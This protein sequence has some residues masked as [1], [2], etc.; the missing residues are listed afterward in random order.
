MVEQ[1]NFINFFSFAQKANDCNTFSEAAE[2][3]FTA[4]KDIVGADSGYIALL[5]ADKNENEVVFLDSGNRPC[6]VDPG[7]PMP[8]RG[9]REKCCRLR[10]AVYDNDYESSKW[11]ELLPSGHVK[12]DN[13]L[14]APIIYKEELLGIIGLANK[15]G[16]FIDE[17][18]ELSSI[19]AKN[20]SITFC[21]MRD[22]E[23]HLESEIKYKNLFNN[24]PV[25]LYVT[26]SMERIVEMNRKMLELL[27]IKNPEELK[28][29]D[30]LKYY[31]NP[32]DRIE[33]QN[34]LERTGAVN[35]L[36][37]QFKG[38]KGEM[39]WISENANLIEGLD[40]QQYC[41][42][43]IEDITTRKKS[44]E[45]FLTTYLKLDKAHLELNLKAEWM[46]KLNSFF[47]DI[48]GIA[49]ENELHKCFLLKLKDYF[50]PDYV[51]FCTIGSD[52]SNFK[53]KILKE[54]N[55]ITHNLALKSSDFHILNSDTHRIIILQESDPRLN[56]EESDFTIYINNLIDKGKNEIILLPIINNDKLTGN[57]IMAVE[58]G[59]LNDNH[60]YFLKG[61]SEF[62]SLLNTNI[63]LLNQAQ[64]SFA[65]LV[66][67]QEAIKKQERI[68]AMG[69]IASGITH[70]IN[71]TLAPITLYTEALIE[72]ETGLSDRAQKYLRNIQNAVADIENVTQRLRTFYKQNKEENMEL[73]NIDELFDDVI[74]LTRPKWK[75]IPNKK[76]VSIILKKSLED[77][78]VEINGVRSDIRE[79]LMNCIFNSVDAMPDGGEI[80]L[81][82]EL[83]RG[84]IQISITDNGLGM[85]KEQLN[86]CMEPF[87][88]TKGAAGTGL[89]LA[90][91]YG[92]VQ[93]HNGEMQVSSTA[94]EGT[95]VNLFFNTSETAADSE[96]NRLCNEDEK[97]CSSPMKILCVD[98]DYR[99][100]EGLKEMFSIDGHFVTVVESGLE[101]LYTL[102]SMY[103][104]NSL[105]DVIITDLGM[106]GMDGY[107]LAGEIK[108]LYPD[109]PI[110]ML[111]GWGHQMK[112][113]EQQS[114]ALFCV[115]PKPPRIKNLREVLGR[116]S[117]RGR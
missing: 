107:Q 114:D 89:G 100:L 111:S 32:E 21:N 86:Q 44:E 66:K 109:I 93:R 81:A 13:V 68:K 5:S 116:V 61:V 105:P 27:G 72:T 84:K 10:S 31:E 57:L 7:L 30:I 22:R 58:K 43:S 115:I 59:F 78:T 106:P 99:I 73:L 17:D 38:K 4:C 6:S 41:E 15:A 82:E 28:S 67:A 71:N 113:A 90:E 37:T 60:L 69:Q 104:I 65:Q 95:S 40:G 54:N 102:K 56:S 51:G 117:D 3:I 108:K 52:N 74:E 45:A 49:D 110:V 47:I 2:I 16:G 77:D 92:M 103:K 11:N 62:L 8:I 63:N 53:F 88:T 14:F 20:A 76:G 39:L 64:D 55:L 34:Q 83:N 91:V 23:K 85:S 18:I 97:I 25:G 94:G 46:E 112:N 70:D 87:F 12:L 98:D 80:I 79:S 33:W 24:L 19:F 1:S 42:V 9:L 50:N 35:Y 26:D 36:E 96:R 29:G 48:A 75:T 101:A